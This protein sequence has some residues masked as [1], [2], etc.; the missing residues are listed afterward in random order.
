MGFQV[1]PWKDGNEDRYEVFTITSNEKWIPRRYLEDDSNESNG[2][3]ILKDSDLEHDVL[4]IKQDTD[5]F[6]DAQQ[7]E[8][9]IFED[10]QTDNYDI[11]SVIP[12]WGGGE[13][14]TLS[15][16]ETFEQQA[17]TLKHHEIVQD[18]SK[19]LREGVVPP[20]HTS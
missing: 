6:M 12:V 11:P 19:F 1:L 2:S 13:D 9:E 16:I 20:D 10:A 15:S 4:V 7:D 3:A 14:S 18:I 8:V 5:I 17:A